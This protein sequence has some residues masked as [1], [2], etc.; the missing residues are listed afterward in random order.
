MSEESQACLKI[1]TYTCATTPVWACLK[2]GYCPLLALLTKH[3]DEMLEELI[4]K[5][6]D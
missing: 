4:K 1:P 3:V 2:L 5:E 6:D